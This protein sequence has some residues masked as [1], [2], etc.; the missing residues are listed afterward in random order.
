MAEILRDKQDD[1]IV[2][3]RSD[4]ESAASVLLAIADGFEVQATTDPDWDSGPTVAAAVD[5][6]RHLLGA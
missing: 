6:A 3:L 2:T 1:G 5:V 4:P